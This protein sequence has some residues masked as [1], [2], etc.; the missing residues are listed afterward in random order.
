MKIHAPSF[1][2]LFVLSII[3][4]TPAT[5]ESKS[6]QTQILTC[7]EGFHISTT[8]DGQQRMIIECRD[9]KV[10]WDKP[11]WGTI[12]LICPD[13]FIGQLIPLEPKGRRAYLRC[14]RRKK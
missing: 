10:P 3:S 2:V 11:P 7:P 12:E 8:N 1:L 4:T 14:V 6:P 5:A 13:N 9:D